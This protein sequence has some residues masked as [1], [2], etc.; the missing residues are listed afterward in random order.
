MARVTVDMRDMIAKR[1]DLEKLLDRTVLDT[2]Q[3]LTLD[4]GKRL[5]EA[6][7][8]DDGTFRGAWVIETP[9]RAFEAGTIT[10][11]TVYGPKLAKGHSPQ[12]DDG[13]IELAVMAAV[14][15]GGG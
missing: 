6:S 3:K 2:T 10:N 8:V 1:N 5:I 4:C 13:W 15:F 9:T 14:R 12:A 7:P 11:N